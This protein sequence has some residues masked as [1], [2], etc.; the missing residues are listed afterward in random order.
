LKKLIP[1]LILILLPLSCGNETS[2][3]LPENVK[4]IRIISLSPSITAQILDLEGSHL[5]VGVTTYSPP[6]PHKVESVGNI[7]NPNVEKIV[8]LKPDAVLYSVEDAAVQRTEQ[9]TSMGIKLFSF[10]RNADYKTICDN[11]RSLARIIGKEELA[12]K[13]LA[14]Y[15]R[16]LEEIKNRSQNRASPSMAFF[17]SQEP[18]ITVSGLSFINGII[19][20]AGGINVYHDL[21]KPYPLV[22]AESL[23]ILKPE[24][25][26]S[27]MAGAEK[28]FSNLTEAY[29]IKN[30]YLSRNIYSI[31]PD[32]VALYTPG[33]YVSSV[34][35]ISGKI[36]LYL[37]K[38][39]K[40]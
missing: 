21:E 10:R 11:F 22:S 1:C 24:I 26:L 23:I 27:M 31:N 28:F 6:L 40:K 29:S 14:I 13:K 4:N 3:S 38:A 36:D 15:N 35:E 7:T 37:K 2:I 25:I 16:K 19:D 12:D 32:N 17:V 20:D 5:L 30:K 39:W 18:L 9:L 33:N 8:L 34:E